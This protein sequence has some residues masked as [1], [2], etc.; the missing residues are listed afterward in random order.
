[1]V[2]P[3]FRDFRREGNG[4]V[5]QATPR[6]CG[7][8]FP[9]CALQKPIADEPDPKVETPVRVLTEL[10]GAA[11]KLPPPNDHSK[12][13]S[14]VH[15]SGVDPRRSEPAVWQRPRVHDTASRAPLRQQLRTKMATKTA[16][17]ATFDSYGQ[18]KNYTCLRNFKGKGAL[19]RGGR[20]NIG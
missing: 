10:M 3:S 12:I 14:A 19:N 11:Q 1:M 2:N 4:V 16:A 7:N 17:A 20:R 8:E 15:P 6:A 13:C 5:S 18:L 9:M